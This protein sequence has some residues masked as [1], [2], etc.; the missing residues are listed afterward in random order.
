MRKIRQLDGA[1]GYWVISKEHKLIGIY[2][3][4][5]M[6]KSSRYVLYLVLGFIIYQIIDTG[7]TGV[8][9][10]DV[11]TTLIIAMVI[12]FIL[13]L[14]VRIIKSRYDKDDE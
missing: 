7:Q 1:Y 6:K 10:D 14:V 3:L 9:H 8:T 5:E 2:N 4:L 11:K 12:V 13:L